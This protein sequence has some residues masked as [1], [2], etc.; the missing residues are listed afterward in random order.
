MKKITLLLVSVLALLSFCLSS[1]EKS[2][3][4]VLKGTWK[5]VPGIYSSNTGSAEELEMTI[6][7]DGKGNFTWTVI[8]FEKRVT[9]GIYRINGNFVYLFYT[10]TNGEGVTMDYK[11]AMEMDLE[12]NPHTLT[13]NTYDSLGN[14][15]AIEAFV[16]Q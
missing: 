2:S 1:C 12:S 10:K 11:M 13:F 15:L 5:Y 14:L 6:V 7:F 4:D 3:G 16:K 8:D 9:E